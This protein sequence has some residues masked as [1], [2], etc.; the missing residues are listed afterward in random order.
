MRR[1]QGPSRRVERPRVREH[2]VRILRPQDIPAC[3]AIIASESLWQRY[4]TSGRSARELIRGAFRRHD[5]LYVA[6]AN[7]QVVGFIWFLLR[8]A[9]AHSGYIRLI[10]VAASARGQGVGTALMEVAEKRIFQSG[11]NVF[12]LVSTFN[13]PAQ[14]FYRRRGYRPVGRVP[15]YVASGLTELIYRKTEGSLRR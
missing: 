1:A 14:Q 3:A 11:P 10:A 7:G 2:Q 13:R 5:C 8:G 12:L 15:D 6:R 4:G 9:F